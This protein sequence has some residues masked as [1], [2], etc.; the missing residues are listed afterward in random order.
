MRDTTRNEAQATFADTV[1]LW[2]LDE[3]TT[4]DV[5]DAAVGCLLG[6][7]DT[8]TLRQLAGEPSSALR[9]DV[10]PMVDRTLVELGLPDAVTEDPLRGATAAMVGRYVRHEISARDLCRWAHGVVGHG[11]DPVSAELALLDGAYDPDDL[12]VV[13]A[14]RAILEAELEADLRRE[15]DQAV[16]RFLARP[17]ES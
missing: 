7:L 17:E 9:P 4:R 3:A 1:R 12:G 2:R 8:P 10:W 13:G 11:E 14:G 16:A 6:G 15:T 5:V